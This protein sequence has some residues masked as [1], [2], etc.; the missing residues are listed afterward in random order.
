MKGSICVWCGQT[1]SNDNDNKCEIKA[2]LDGKEK[3]EP[4]TIQDY[5]T[6]LTM[7]EGNE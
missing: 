1:C 5:E 7:D 4:N 6:C 2:F 3:S